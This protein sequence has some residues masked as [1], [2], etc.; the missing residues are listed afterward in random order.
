MLPWGT[1]TVVKDL[2]IRQAETI[3]AGESATVAVDTRSSVCSDRE[4]WFLLKQHCGQIHVV[5]PANGTLVINARP[6]Q[7]A[8]IE[9]VVFSATSGGAYRRQISWPGTVTLLEVRAFQSYRIFVG[10]PAGMASQT[11]SVTTTLKPPV[12]PDEQE[13]TP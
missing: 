4:G 9:P 6:L 5:A 2:V 7:D 10:S 13:R 11:Y 3:T 12:S 8:T 1:T